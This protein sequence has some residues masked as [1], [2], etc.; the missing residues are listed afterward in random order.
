MNHED[1]QLVDRLDGFL[2]ATIMCLTDGAFGEAK[3]S[4][5]AI[6][7]GKNGTIIDSLD[8]HFCFSDDLL[9]VNDVQIKKLETKIIS[10][11]YLEESLYK[12]LPTTKEKQELLAWHIVE[13]L[14]IL[15]EDKNVL[16]VGE[17]EMSDIVT[18]HDN[19]LKYQTSNHLFV[20]ELPN[21]LV[22]LIFG[23]RN[24]LIKK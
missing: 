21:E 4:A 11:L 5:G 8:T 20:I 15:T 6:L 7:I 2:N 9:T 12:K 24:Y 3:S 13:M 22:V 14:R 18:F 1:K 17:Y 16:S 10:V 23:K 19:E